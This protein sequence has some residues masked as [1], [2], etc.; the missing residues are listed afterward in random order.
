MLFILD[1]QSVR[2]FKYIKAVYS[3]NT[4]EH[5]H[6]LCGQNSEFNA[7]LITNI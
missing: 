2:V 7:I 1:D 4:T 6:I 3:E 5:I